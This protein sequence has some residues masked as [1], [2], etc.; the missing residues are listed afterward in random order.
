M[1]LVS[2]FQFWTRG[3]ILMTIVVLIQ[4]CSINCLS[5][6]LDNL[7]TE[8]ELEDYL[9]QLEGSLSDQQ[10]QGNKY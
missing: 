4:I 9:Q 2:W 6:D 8:D 7:I 5:N 10:L 3:I 1:K